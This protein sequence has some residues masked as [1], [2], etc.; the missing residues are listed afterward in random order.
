M[1][2]HADWQLKNMNDQINLIDYKNNFKHARE[3]RG[4]KPLRFVAVGL[5]FFVSAL[6]II[7]FMLIALSPI[8]Q[9]KINQKNASLNL[10]LLNKDI[11]KLSLVKDR[12]KAV[13]LLLKKR[14]DYNSAL[15]S[16]DAVIPAGV[17]IES[18]STKSDT[19]SVTV[20]SKSLKLLDNFTKNLELSQESV[21]KFSKIKI[22]SISTEDKKD[23]FLLIVDMKIL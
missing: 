21:N 3:F 4:Q 5:L 10:G 1:R 9:L 19:I 20:S 15:D 16:L 11:A 23:T 13:N 6:A 7:L 8:P 14:S 22:I 18:V 2:L 12:A 17:S